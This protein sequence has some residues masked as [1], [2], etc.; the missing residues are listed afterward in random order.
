MIA[1][2]GT[3]EGVIIPD[4]SDILYFYPQ[5]VFDYTIFRVLCQNAE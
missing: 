1:T 3:P 2:A 5:I 4:N